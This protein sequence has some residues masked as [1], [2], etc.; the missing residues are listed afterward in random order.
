MKNEKAG[1]GVRACKH[2][3]ASTK[4]LEYGLLVEKEFIDHEN[5]NSLT[6]L[7]FYNHESKNIGSIECQVPLL[8]ICKIVT[9][10]ELQT[11][12]NPRII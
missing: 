12:K 3:F 8:W 7:G 9:N 6:R 1:N 4:L 11:N 10:N 2:F 5:G